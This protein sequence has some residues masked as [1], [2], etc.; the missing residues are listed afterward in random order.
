MYVAVPTVPPNM[1]HKDRLINENLYSGHLLKL[2]QEQ[3]FLVY[4][5]NLFLRPMIQSSQSL[6]PWWKPESTWTNIMTHAIRFQCL[7]LPSL[8]LSRI[9]SPPIPSI[10]MPSLHSC[11]SKDLHRR[12]RQK[13]CLQCKWLIRQSTIEAPGITLTRGVCPLAV[14]STFSHRNKAWGSYAL[15]IVFYARPPVSQRLS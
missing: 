4:G 15:V 1:K 7:K 5:Q 9:S 11:E 10:F 6:E 13:F 3:G 8:K 12:S 14:I 2:E